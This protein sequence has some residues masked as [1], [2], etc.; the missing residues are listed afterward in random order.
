MAWNEITGVFEELSDQVNVIM[1][2]EA[3]ISN[4]DGDIPITIELE[5]EGRIY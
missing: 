1:E 2:N 5:T 4:I 3:T